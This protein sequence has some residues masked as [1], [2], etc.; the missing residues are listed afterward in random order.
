MQAGG[1][2]DDQLEVCRGITIAFQ[3]EQRERACVVVV[4]HVVV[5]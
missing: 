2:R 5:C 1:G 4:E 3:R